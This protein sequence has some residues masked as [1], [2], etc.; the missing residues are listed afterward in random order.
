MWSKIGNLAN[1]GRLFSIILIWTGLKRCH[2]KITGDKN[3]NKLFFSSY[4]IIF[5]AFTLICPIVSLYCSSGCK[6]S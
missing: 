1:Q 4:A 5:E 3:M 6:T 2:L